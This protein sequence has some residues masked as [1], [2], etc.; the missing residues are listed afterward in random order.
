[1]VPSETSIVFPQISTIAI[2]KHIYL[3]DSYNKNKYYKRVYMDIYVVQKG[4]TIEIIAN[5]YGISVDKLIRDNDLTN[6]KQLVPGECIIILYPSQTYIVQEGDTLD[7]IAALNNISVNELLRNNPIISDMNYIYPGEMLTI[8]YNRTG[9]IATHGYTNTFI[10]RQILRKTLPYLTYLSIFNY[11]IVKNGDAL[12]SND[13]IDIIQMAKE[14]GVLPL[15]HL[16]TLTIQG[17]IDL[18]TTY[19]IL[20]NEELQNKLFD[21]I[22]KVLEEKGYYGINISAQYITSANQAIFNNYT[23]RLSERLHQEGFLCVITINPKIDTL[24][25]EVIYE[26]IDYSNITSTVDSVIFIQYRWGINNSP[27]APIISISNLNIFLDYALSQIEPEKIITAIPMIGYIWELP[28]VTGFSS[29]NSLT[30]DNAINLARDVGAIIQFDEKSQT[31]YFTF[32]E[33]S[34]N[35]QYIVWFINAITINSMIKL[36]LEKGINGTGVWN[37]M[38]YSTQLWLVINSQYEIIKLLPEF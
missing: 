9:R 4:D 12:G 8:S 23:K 25:N 5:N 37:I 11:R 19:E 21:N 13:D 38:V 14:Y 10:N 6:P 28:F 33:T 26:I 34:N 24:N 15:L 3:I 29:S 17:D 20:I 18:E 2:V 27:P 35:I 32:E 36:L 30:I 1:M 16:S 31:P 7:A 22:L